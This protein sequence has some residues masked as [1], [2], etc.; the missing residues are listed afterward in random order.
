[1]GDFKVNL[2][3][4][5]LSFSLLLDVAE[6]KPFQHAKKVSYIT[7]LTVEKMDRNDLK[8]HAFQGAIL[9]DI[10]VTH[11][12]LLQGRKAFVKAEMN[13]LDHHATTGWE[14]AKELPLNQE[15]SEIIRYHHERWD[16]TGLYGLKGDKIPLLS[17]IIALAD[18]LELRFN[19]GRDSLAF[20]KDIRQWLN[21]E[22]GKGFREDIVDAVLELLQKEKMWIDI[23]TYDIQPNLKMIIPNKVMELNINELEQISRAFAIIIDKK[24]DFT[25]QHSIGVSEKAYKLAKAFNYDEE[26][27]T[28]M[29]IAGYLHDLGKL[30][31]PNEILD[32]PGG[33][34]DEEMLTIKKHPY[35][36]KFILKQ[37]SGFEEIA[38][39]S[40]NHHENLKGSGYPEGFGGVNMTEECQII[41]VCDIYQALTED[42]IYRKGMEQEKALEIISKL[43]SQGYF[44]KYIF[45]NL[46][47]AST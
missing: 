30:L 10:G 33:L 24:S 44:E 42:R 21:S 2:N 36:T 29:K 32:K 14:V 8:N 13:N 18:Q 34:D 37:I 38:E 26:K 39:W 7:L 3:E 27:C 25:H 22:K 4:I 31:V 20:R 43:V 47:L 45:D 5:L 9:H 11:S 1:M 6:K 19:S 12:L 15:V 16:G 41:A 35:Y 28:K 40:G 23:G 17:Q 46:C